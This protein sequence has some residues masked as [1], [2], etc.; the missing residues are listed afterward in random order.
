MGS[1]A[2]VIGGPGLV[3]GGHSMVGRAAKLFI[4]LTLV[5]VRFEKG[6]KKIET[7]LETLIDEKIEINKKGVLRPYTPHFIY[8]GTGE[9]I[10][11]PYRS[12][13][14]CELKRRP[15]NEAINRLKMT[16]DDPTCP[17]S[18]DIF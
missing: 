13:L 2:D 14:L 3:E 9:A 15:T 4:T 1:A 16:L 10:H 5:S 12:H 11:Y 17:T 7:S 6:G 8:H 18:K